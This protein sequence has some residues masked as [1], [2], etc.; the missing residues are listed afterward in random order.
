MVQPFDSLPGILKIESGY[1]GGQ[2]SN[3]TYDE[4]KTGKTGHYEVVQITFDLTHF[5][6]Q[7]LLDLYWPQIDPTDDEGQFHD[8]GN[9]YRTAIFFHNKKQRT[10]AEYSKKLLEESNR[11]QKSIVTEILPAA[12]FYPAEEIHQHYYKKEP[13]AYKQDRQKSGRDEFIDE[14][15][16]KQDVV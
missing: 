1:M 14:H 7:Q 12:T 9:Q 4:V 5:S 13:T 16:P 8:R 11:F 10:A 15:W 6:Y 2:L 3:P